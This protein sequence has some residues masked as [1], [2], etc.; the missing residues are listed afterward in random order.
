MYKAIQKQEA[1]FRA[2][3]AIRRI[4]KELVEQQVTMEKARETTELNYHT[5][6]AR[7]SKVLNENFPDEYVWPIPPLVTNERNKPESTYLSSPENDSN[8]NTQ[9]EDFTEEK[10]VKKI[11]VSFLSISHS[12]PFIPKS[13]CLLMFI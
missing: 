12:L 8:R 2:R 7:I 5:T 10:R 1:S 6:M 4:Y 11:P 3:L 13:N 9:P